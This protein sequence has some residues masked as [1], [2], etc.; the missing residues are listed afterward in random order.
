ME[1]AVRK[2]NA[3]AITES[4]E[5]SAEAAILSVVPQAGNN[6]PRWWVGS[7]VLPRLSVIGSI[8]MDA[9]ALLAGLALAGYLVGGVSR[10]AEMVRF[11]PVL[12]VVWFMIFVAWDLYTR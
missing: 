3:N 7:T 5:S 1:S 10:V 11:A 2:E 4:A 6:S 9:F 8:T 12:L